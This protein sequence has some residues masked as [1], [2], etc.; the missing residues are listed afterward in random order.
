MCSFDMI[1]LKD[2]DLMRIKEQFTHFLFPNFCSKS[3]FNEPTLA[4]RSLVNMDL[5][6]ISAVEFT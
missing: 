3:I 2:I 1:V 6:T 4:G 5:N